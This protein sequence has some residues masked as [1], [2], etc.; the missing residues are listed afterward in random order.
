MVM[1]GGEPTALRIVANRY[2]GKKKPDLLKGRAFFTT[3]DQI[4]HQ[5]QEPLLQPPLLQPP[6][7]PARGTFEVMEKPER[8][9]ASTK[10]TRISPQV[11]KR[12]FSTRNLSP[13]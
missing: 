3:D 1:V 5:P 11:V 6:L 7:A 12:P 8:G 2:E 9:P 10:S 13:S 4:F